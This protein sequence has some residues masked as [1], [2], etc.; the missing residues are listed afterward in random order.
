LVKK[1]SAKERAA[2]TGRKVRTPNGLGFNKKR[3]PE[4]HGTKEAPKRGSQK[5]LARSH[6]VV[7][8]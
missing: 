6:L 5:T 7:P 1:E 8:G 4:H 2:P 3:G